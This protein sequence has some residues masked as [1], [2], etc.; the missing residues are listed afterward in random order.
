MTQKTWTAVDDYIEAKLVP[1]DSVLE[2]ALAASEE[3]G[4]PSI[5]VSSTQGRLL[6]ILAQAT[7]AKRILEIGTLG[8]YSTTWLARALPRDGKL[9]TL[10]ADPKHAEVARKNLKHAGFGELAEVRLGKALET[11]PKLASEG[12]RPFDMIFIDANKNDYPGYLEWAIKLSRPG[13][14]IVA[15][16]VIRDGRVADAGDS[17]PNVQGVRRM[18]EIAAAEPGLKATAIQTVGSRGYDGLFIAVVDG[19]N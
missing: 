8:A 15:D 12:H 14:L 5:A 4:L 7:R 2:G 17:D 9:I 11:L 18:Y 1:A 16:N 19:D 6:M 10:E 3:A 13:T